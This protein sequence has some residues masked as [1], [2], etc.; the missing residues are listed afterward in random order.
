MP[1]H[2]TIERITT[3][4]QNKTN[5]SQ[6]NQ[7][8]KPYGNPNSKDLNKSHSSRLVGGVEK[9]RMAERQGRHGVAWSGG[10]VGSPI[11]HIVDKN[12]EGYLVSERSHPAPG[13]TSQPTVSAPG[14]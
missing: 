1:S 9:W 6:N 4:S 7:E 5:N 8:I 12:Q 3:R 11:F 2:T 10:G 14:S 13:Q